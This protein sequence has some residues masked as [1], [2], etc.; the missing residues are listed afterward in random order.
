MEWG[1][2]MMRMGRW[3][4]RGR[5]GKEEERLMVG[6]LVRGLGLLEMLQ[7]RV[8]N[9]RERKSNRKAASQALK[10]STAIAPNNEL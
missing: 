1:G 4:G 9:R 8:N 6:A 10:E 7:S 3:G 2:K 5:K